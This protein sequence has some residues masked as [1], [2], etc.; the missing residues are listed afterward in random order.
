MKD[1]NFAYHV[2]SKDNLKSIMKEGL[3]PRIPKDYGENGDIKGVYM[4]K[5]LEDTKNA[6]MNWLGE[7]MEEWEEENNEIYNDI[8]LKIN[9]KG[10][11][12]SLYDSVEF[13]WISLD[14]IK[15]E[16][17]IEVLDI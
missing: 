5:T 10:L 4:F 6:L 12:D 14:C 3:K 9:I 8:T 17:I 1:S 7:R 11:K 13:E 2:T 15:P 16:R